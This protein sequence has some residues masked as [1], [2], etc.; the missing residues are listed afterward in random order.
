MLK[1]RIQVIEI[2]TIKNEGEW[3]RGEQ[4]HGDYSR[5]IF[6]TNNVDIIMS[7]HGRA[8]RYDNLKGLENGP[9]VGDR[10]EFPNRLFSMPLQDQMKMKVQVESGCHFP[11]IL[12]SLAL[13]LKPIEKFSA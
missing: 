12:P 3:G 13:F 11:L 10:D 2:R 4:A 1:A 8:Q 5:T 9:K 6:L 7:T